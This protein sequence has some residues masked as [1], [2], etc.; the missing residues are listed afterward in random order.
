MGRVVIA[1]VA[2]LLAVPVAASARVIHA[3]SDGAAFRQ[4]THD[5]LRRAAANAA[6]R[7]GGDPSTWRR[8]R[9]MFDVESLGLAAPP[10]LKSY[11]RGTWQQAV[12]LGP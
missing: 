11:D 9:L 8:P 10:P 4:L 3:E 5:G 2:A 6:A 1:A 7:L 12:E